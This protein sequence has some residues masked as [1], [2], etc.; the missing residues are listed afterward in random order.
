MTTQTN[1][2]QEAKQALARCETTMT[3]KLSNTKCPT[4][5]GEHDNHDHYIVT[6]KN[7]MGKYSFDP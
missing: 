7:H 3:V 4:W 1:Y 2:Q 6:L 5:A